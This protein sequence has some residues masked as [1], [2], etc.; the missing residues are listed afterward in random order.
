MASPTITFILIDKTIENS[1]C[2]SYYANLFP[3]NKNHILELVKNPRTVVYILENS[4]QGQEIKNIILTKEEI[5]SY[6]LLKFIIENASNKKFCV[7]NV[8]LQDFENIE[9]TTVYKINL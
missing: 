3:F 7:Q 8:R 2:V 5:V 6:K 4:F 1:S 9:N